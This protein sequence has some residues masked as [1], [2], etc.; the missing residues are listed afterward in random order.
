[1]PDNLH[2]VEGPYKN[3]TVRRVRPEDVEKVEQHI[4]DY[5]LHDEPTSKLSGYTE[6]YGNEFC[7][8]FR[9]FLPDNLSFW[10]E[11]NETG[12]VAAV[13]ATFIHKKDDN[14][15]DFFPRKSL[16]SKNLYQMCEI[17]LEKGNIYE[18]YG[19]TE[20]ADFLVASCATKYRN[21]G[22]AKELYRR[23]MELFKVEGIKLAKSVFTS[24]FSRAAVKRLGFEEICRV[25]YK[26]MKD[27][28]GN[29]V[30]DPS[31]LTDEHFG[32]V[33]VKLV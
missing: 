20:Y 9:H 12:E 31:Q 28:D 23:S 1:M 21:Q 13:R 16:A 7:H 5:F 32:A 19:I 26:T 17:A 25:D 15:W 3:F 2:L 8:I 29:P 14:C 18:R 22:L 11:D 30:F 27:K 10:M 33:M 6:E 4:E 24:P